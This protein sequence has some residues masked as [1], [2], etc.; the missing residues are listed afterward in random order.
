MKISHS[1]SKIFAGLALA[2]A[3]AAGISG[4]SAASFVMRAESTIGVVS[5]FHESDRSIPFGTEP[6]GGI[7]Y[8]PIIEFTTADG[9]EREFTA[10]RGT[11]DPSYQTGDSVSVL[12]L[13]EN[14]EQAGIQSLW[15]QWGPTLVLLL[16]AGFFGVCALVFRF[17][18]DE[19]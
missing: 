16:T 9:E 19:S 10:D 13:P 3:V 1:A 6:G 2:L 11:Q 5:D 18:F 12:Y 4:I 17:R 8:F 15:G 7:H 14:P